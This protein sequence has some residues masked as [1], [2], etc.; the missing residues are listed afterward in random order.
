[1]AGYETGSMENDPSSIT[2]EHGQLKRKCE[3]CSEWKPRAL[4]AEARVAELEAD[5]RRLNA[6]VTTHDIRNP[7]FSK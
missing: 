3:I 1:M 4:E 7:P 5:N 6:I 2:C